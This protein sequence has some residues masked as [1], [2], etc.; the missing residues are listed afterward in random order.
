MSASFTRSPLTASPSRSRRWASSRWITASEVSYCA[1]PASKMPVT[2]KRRMR[3]STPAG[4]IRACGTTRVTRPPTVASSLSA[5]SRPSSTLKRPGARLSK[6]PSTRYP[7]TSD[8]RGSRA[9]ETPRIST[10]R[11]CPAWVSIPC[12]STNG[13]A[14]TTSGC[15]SAASASDSHPSSEPSIPEIVACEA[16]PRMRSRSSRSK[17][18]MTEITVIRAVAPSAI[19]IIEVRLMKEMKWLRRFA[20]V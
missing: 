11:T 17:P 10:P 6:S 15:A 19:P 4:V 20:R 2:V 5:R 18:F 16:T 8:T 7:P 1:C 14:P 12:N 3:G 13:A 9:G